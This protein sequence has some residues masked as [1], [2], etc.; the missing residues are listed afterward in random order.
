MK[1]TKKIIIMDLKEVINKLENDDKEELVIKVIDWEKEI[2]AIKNAIKF[3]GWK[4]N[5]K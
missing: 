2:T 3:I 5:G 1:T 4:N